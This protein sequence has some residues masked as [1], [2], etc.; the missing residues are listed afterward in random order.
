LRLSG[1]SDGSRMKAAPL[2]CVTP[3]PCPAAELAS[4]PKSRLET[5]RAEVYEFSRFFMCTNHS[6][7]DHLSLNEAS[8]R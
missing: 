6:H 3:D 8:F 1:V 2:F 4:S 5:Q 7:F